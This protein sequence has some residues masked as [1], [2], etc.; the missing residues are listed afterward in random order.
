M[1]PTI[2][3]IANYGNTVLANLWNVNAWLL[4]GLF[5]VMTLLLFYALERAI[6][7]RRDRVVSDK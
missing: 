2:S 7:L 6:R 4:I 3:A 5:T 1:F